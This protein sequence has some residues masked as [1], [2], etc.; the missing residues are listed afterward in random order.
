[1]LLDDVAAGWRQNLNHDSDVGLMLQE[2]LGITEFTPMDEIDLERYGYS[3]IV[4]R[5]G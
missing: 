3:E 5:F 2:E 4:A 1:M